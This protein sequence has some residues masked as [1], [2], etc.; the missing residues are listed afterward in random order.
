MP[1]SHIPY[2][3]YPAI[4]VAVFARQMWLPVPAVFFLIMAGALGESGA[5]GPNGFARD[6]IAEIIK[7]FGCLVAITL[8]AW[9]PKKS[10]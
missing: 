3:T 1:S 9:L 4:L 8:F 2:L 7:M 6:D 10:A 5:L